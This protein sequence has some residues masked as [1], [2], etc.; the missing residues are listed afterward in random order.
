MYIVY[1]IPYFLA[2]RSLWDQLNQS[3]EHIGSGDVHAQLM[4]KYRK[5]PTWWFLILLLPMMGLSVF[6]CEGFRNELQL[7]YWG[8]ILA[9]LLVLF[10]IPPLAS[11]R[12]TVAQVGYSTPSIFLIILPNYSTIDP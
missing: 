8:V 5:I 6:A 1:L 9:F 4:N 3:N 12:A 10:L 7:P 11:L 2:C